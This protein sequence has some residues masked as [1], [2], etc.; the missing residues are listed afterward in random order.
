MNN[1]L[2]KAIE[3]INQSNCVLMTTHTK[4]DGDACGSVVAMSE[5]LRALGKSVIPL[6]LSTVPTWYEFL[7]TEKVPVLGEDIQLDELKAGGLGDFD[8]IVI[9]DTNSTSQL[10]TFDEFLKSNDKPVL[11]IDHHVISDGLGDIEIVDSSASATGLIVLDLFKHTGWAITEKI[12]EAL[13]IAIATDTGW[14]QFSNTDSRT[15]RGCAELIEA[16]AK[17]AMIYEKLYHTFSQARF[18]LMIAMLD[19]LELHFDDRY[20]VMQITRN[21]F[22]RTGAEY[23]DTENLI[24]EAHRIATVTTTALFIELKDGRVRCSLRSRDG[25]DVSRIAAQF[26]GGGHKQAAGTFLPG[27]LE[28]AKQLI[29]AEITKDIDKN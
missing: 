9:V 7:F 8:L 29:M 5:A 21:D 16:G 3:L 10:P 24:N 2:Q 19:S 15:H 12:A 26:G 17:S 1:D 20:A 27:P 23:S 22:E 25:L 11:I 4:P 18:K 28:K 14:F 6:L 13:F